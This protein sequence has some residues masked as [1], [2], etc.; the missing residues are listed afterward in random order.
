MHGEDTLTRIMSPVLL[1]ASGKIEK[2][3]KRDVQGREK[4]GVGIGRYKE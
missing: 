1:L 3:L 2:R 4:L